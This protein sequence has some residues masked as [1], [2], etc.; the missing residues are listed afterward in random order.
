[1]FDD[2]IPAAMASVEQMWPFHE[3]LVQFLPDP[4][5]MKPGRFHHDIGL[6]WPR[7]GSGDLEEL[8]VNPALRPPPVEQTHRDR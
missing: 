4:G 7:T 2:C 6:R 3:G 5:A 1:M 8:M